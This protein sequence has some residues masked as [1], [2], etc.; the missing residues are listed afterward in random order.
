[1]RWSIALL[2]AAACGSSSGVTERTPETDRRYKEAAARG[3]VKFGMT[4][5]EVRTALG[6]PSRTGKTTYKGRP[7]TYWAYLYTDI[8]FDEDGLVAGWQTATG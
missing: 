7:A 5:D 1:M 3:E 4:R 6:K 2:L 8:Y